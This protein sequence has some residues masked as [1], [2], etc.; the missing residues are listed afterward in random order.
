M[1]NLPDELQELQ[2]SREGVYGPA[3]DNMAG[4]SKQMEGLSTNWYACHR[5][6]RCELPDWWCPLM[7]CAV[8]LNRIASGN[9]HGDN[10]KDLRVYLSFVEEMQREQTKE[11]QA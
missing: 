1:S 6:E 11:D 9:Y 8:K 4:T 5:N 7:M 3:M 2:T 10:F